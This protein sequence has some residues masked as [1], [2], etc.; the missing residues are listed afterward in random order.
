MQEDARKKYAELTTGSVMLR[1]TYDQLAPHLPPKVLAQLY[2]VG[3]YLSNML[4]DM[5][6]IYG[7]RAIQGAERKDD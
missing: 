2:S 3:S 6:L 5:E 1:M 7:Q 4:V